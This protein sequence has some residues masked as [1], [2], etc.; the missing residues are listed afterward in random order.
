M[1]TK[2]GYTPQEIFGKL[3]YVEE[4]ARQ[5]G[6]MAESSKIIEVSEQTY[7]RWR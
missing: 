3:S 7:Y 6:T 1:K 2:R 4:L 5:G